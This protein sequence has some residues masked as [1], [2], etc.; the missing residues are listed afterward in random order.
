MATR[1]CEIQEAR[2]VE[3]SAVRDARTRYSH[4]LLR[5]TEVAVAELAGG[6]SH[7]N[8]LPNAFRTT[9][10]LKS[11]SEKLCKSCRYLENTVLYH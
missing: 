2:S 1:L 6:P 8:T 11:R 4:E 9:I 3:E 5:D 7:G 10:K